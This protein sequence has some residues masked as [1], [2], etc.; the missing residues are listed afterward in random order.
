MDPRQDI[1]MPQ[2]T[3]PSRLDRY[4]VRVLAVAL[5][6]A[7]LAHSTRITEPFALPKQIILLAAA[8]ALLGLAIA[9]HLF[10][11]DSSPALV[12]AAFWPAGLYLVAAAVATTLAVNRGLALW[13][14]LELGSGLAIGWGVTRFLRD[15][16]GA[17]LLFKSAAAAAVL[18][19]AGMLAQVFLPGAYLS[20]AGVSLLPAVRAGSTLGD[21]G[22]A[23]AYLLLAVPACIGAAAL[24]RGAWR[25]LWGAATGLP[26]AAL[27]Y[28]GRPESWIVGVVLLALLAAT[29]LL[30]VAR[31]GRRWRALLPDLSGDGL[32]ALLAALIVLLAVLSLARWPD[33]NP[34]GEP[35]ES[36]RG[37]T[38]LSPT[39]GDPVVDRA[40]ARD[41]APELLRLHPL[42]VGPDMWRHA[43]LEVCWTGKTPSPFSLSHQSVHPGNAF[44]EAAAETGVAGGL[45]LAAL[46]LVLLIQAARAACGPPGPWSA[47][48]YAALNLLACAMVIG[49]FGAP[50]HEPATAMLFWAMAGL[51]QPALLGGADGAG[52]ARLL[53]P[54]LRPFVP[55]PVR[56]RAWS[57]VAAAVWIAVVTLLAWQLT[58][59]VQASADTLLGRAAMTA[60][61]DRLAAQLLTRPEVKRSPEHLPHVLLGSVYLRLGFTEQ[62][63]AAFDAALARSPFFLAAYLGR[64]SAYTTAGRY[65]LADDDLRAALRLWPANIDTLMVLAKLQTTRGRLDEALQTYKRIST[66]NDTLAE[67][68]YHMGEIFAR[69]GQIDEAIEVLQIC[70]TKNPRYPHLN[71]SLGDVFYRKGLL[72][73]ALRYY[74]GSAT[75]DEKS[76]EARLKIANTYHAMGQYCDAREALEAAR[77]LETDTSLRLQILDMIKKV[78]PACRKQG[79]IRFH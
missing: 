14:F 28:A 67:P 34:G 12:S 47:A 20:I 44:I 66:L 18:V 72:E 41:R 6:V 19:S 26:A 52:A 77:D 46:C 74:Q 31:G 35:V 69:R 10:E 70:S 73:M 23:G 1:G 5:F 21:P 39:T 55:R 16:S 75:Q 64:A 7:P 8:V 22:L 13:G 60:G 59:R 49:F 63:A 62:A 68:Y 78:D 24:S 54:R 2:V 43:F 79:T 56:R 38:L 25:T 57:G 71:L 9:S 37:I 61:N 15:P 4:A 17:G 76:V 27:L 3:N 65:D 50:L 58:V 32:R 42:G 48:G 40:A 33:L 51:V 11:A 53:T 45:A 29:R 30:Q 36:L